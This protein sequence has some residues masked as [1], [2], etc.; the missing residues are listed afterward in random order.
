M[1]A[2]FAFFQKDAIAELEK[3]KAKLMEKKEKIAEEIKAIDE[4]IANLKSKA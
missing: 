2:F 3:D 4:K 1:G